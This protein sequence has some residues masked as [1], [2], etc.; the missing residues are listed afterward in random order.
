MIDRIYDT[1]IDEEELRAS[2][3]RPP[4]RSPTP[5]SPRPYSSREFIREMGAYLGKER[6]DPASRRRDS[7]VFAAYEK[8]VPIFCPAFSRLLG[9]L[10][11]RR[12]PARAPGQAHGL[13]RLGQGLLRAD[14]AQD[15][16]PHHRPAHDRRRRAEELRPGHRRRR[17]DPR[18]R[19]LRC[20]STPSR[21]PSPTS[22]TAPSPAPRSR[23]P[24]AGA[25]STLTYEQMVF[26]EATLAC[27]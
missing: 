25:R 14:A 27:R 3:T 24:P 15:R 10:R 20:T 17:R 23:K 7:I 16:E 1:F 4:T 8:D 5:S 22:A 11:P 12:P 6:Q 2:A 18:R 21:S 19:S 26:S 9:R 13:H